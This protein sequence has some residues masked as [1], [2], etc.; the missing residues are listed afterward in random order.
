MTGAAPALAVEGLTVRFG[1]TTALDTVSLEIP[2][3]H[4]V[5]LVGESGSG[6]STL[7]KAVLGV[8]PSAAGRILVDG[9]TSVVSAAG[10]ARVPAEG[11]DDPAGPVL[12]AEPTAHHRADAGRG[13]RPGRLQRAPAPRGHPGGAGRR[14][15]APD[16]I[17]RYPHE[18]SGGQ[19]QRVAIA[20]A[21][22]T[23]PA[24]V[25]A[26]E[27]TSALDV[28]VQAEVL[29]LLG[30]LRSELDLT[31]LFISHNLAVVKQI[32]DDVVVLYRGRVVESAAAHEV[33]THPAHEYT[34]RLL[35]S[36][37]GSR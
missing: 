12:V 4:T 28:S 35:A 27:M 2:K 26:D 21:L 20:R 5:G 6:K 9:P 32:S 17:E 24:V 13:S 7:A 22:I 33:F 37:P 16:A 30:R 3:G 34:R 31:I 14:R 1:R 15:P 11:A 8:V 19:R 36:V 10:A 25:I 29:R 23:G 18:F